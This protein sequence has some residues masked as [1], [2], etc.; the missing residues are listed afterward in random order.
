MTAD[1]KLLAAMFPAL[2]AT[3]PIADAIEA[4]MDSHGIDW[5]SEKSKFFSSNRY[6]HRAEPNKRRKV[7]TSKLARRRNRR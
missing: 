1:D 5:S 2:I 3:E 4:R 7:K 6:R